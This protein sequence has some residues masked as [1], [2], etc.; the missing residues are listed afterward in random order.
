MYK[1]LKS[2]KQFVK[3]EPTFALTEEF[4]LKELF[5]LHDYFLP[6]FSVRAFWESVNSQSDSLSVSIFSSGLNI[7]LLLFS[8]NFKLIYETYSF[9]TTEEIVEF[10]ESTVDT[11]FPS[12]DVG[13]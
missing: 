6:S 11:T 8:Y 1:E 12:I 13:I 9:E 3:V 5:Y 7:K 10:M 4:I 2:T